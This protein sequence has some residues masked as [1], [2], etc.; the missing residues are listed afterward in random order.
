MKVKI[1]IHFSIFDSL[2]ILNLLIL[3]LDCILEAS[4]LDIKN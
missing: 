1:E 3:K 2:L 4:Y